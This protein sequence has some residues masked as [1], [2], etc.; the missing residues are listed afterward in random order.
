[1]PAVLCSLGPQQIVRL[2]VPGIAN[3][4]VSSLRDWLAAPLE[5]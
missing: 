1:M 2:K 4:M 5:G 3:A